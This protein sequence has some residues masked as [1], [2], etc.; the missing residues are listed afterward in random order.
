M[1]GLWRK[2]SHSS[3]A[4]TECVEVAALMNARGVAARDSKDPSGLV[5][6]FSAADWRG[7]VE[8]LVSGK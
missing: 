7:L 4:G 5:L 8:R 1:R 3:G 2:S 6:A